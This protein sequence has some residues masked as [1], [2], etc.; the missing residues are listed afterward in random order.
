M[1]SEPR[2]AGQGDSA[3]PI[4]LRLL[5]HLDRL[6]IASLPEAT[7]SDALQL[8]EF[9]HDWTRSQPS[10]VQY[11]VQQLA[12]AALAAA[13][14][15]LYGSMIPDDSHYAFCLLLML[16]LSASLA[17]YDF[18]RIVAALRNRRF[19]SDLLRQLIAGTLQFDQVCRRIPFPFQLLYSARSKD[20]FGQSTN[21]LVHNLDWY[22]LKPRVCFRASWLIIVAGGISAIAF[23]VMWIGGTSDDY[24]IIPMFVSC[25]ISAIGI[26]MDR[27]RV[28][29][30]AGHLV[31]L[32][33]RDF[34]ITKQ[35]LQ[36]QQG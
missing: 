31:S 19:G 18:W 13:L 21:F 12:L 25:L 8:P 36:D 35:E 5:K 11:L 29:N 27:W 30:F 33:E 26:Q 14:A 28:W 3:S 16:G 4:V 6:C 2:D 22:V 24:T 10:K 23:L 15:W 17:I 32:I 20:G 1:G 9:R 7:Y 34:L